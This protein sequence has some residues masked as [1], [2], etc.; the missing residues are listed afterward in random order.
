VKEQQIE[1]VARQACRKEGLAFISYV[2][3]GA[4][5]S[6]FVA[7]K[8][9]LKYAVKV[10]RACER[11]VRTEREIIAMQRCSHPNIIGLETMG[12]VELESSTYTYFVE[13]FVS[14]GTLT[15]NVLVNHE[16]VDK[17]GLSVSSAIEHLDGLNLVHRDIKP[18]NILIDG[19]K[20]LLGDLGVVR[21]LNDTS[22]TQTWAMRGPGTPLYASPEQLNNEKAL[23]DWRSDQFS[24]GV[25]LSYCLLGYHPYQ[26][27]EAD[28]WQTVERVAQRLGCSPKF[29]SEIKDT[30]YS[31]IMKMVAPWPAQRF[32]STKELVRLWGKE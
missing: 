30:R 27:G 9:G 23:I 14:G 8:T 5:K 4:Y 31:C 16:M 17:V 29:L 32:C 26:V 21:D 7:E 13:Q 28:D 3:E 15:P 22:L 1:L 18:D 6:T 19:D 12:T 2:A 20:V 11:T 25:V 24:L 10:L